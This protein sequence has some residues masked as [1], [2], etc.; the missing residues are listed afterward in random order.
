MRLCT[1]LQHSSSE[2][3]SA[4]VYVVSVLTVLTVLAT[5]ALVIT[6]E[7][8]VT[9]RYLRDQLQAE[10]LAWAG[11][12]MA[13]ARAQSDPEGWLPAD[14][15]GLVV[16]SRSLLDGEDEGLVTVYAAVSSGSKGLKVKLVATGTYRTATRQ[17]TRSLVFIGEDGSVEA[18]EPS[19]T[20]MQ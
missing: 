19:G 10:Q 16:E 12:E 1:F 8:R 6:K 20:G 13:Y 9:T 4:L 11:L 5:S 7:Q 17:L 18:G 3:G 15:G 2:K 14:P